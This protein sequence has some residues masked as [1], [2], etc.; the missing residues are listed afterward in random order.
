MRGI[1]TLSIFVALAGIVLPGC[2]S[3]DKYMKVQDEL[4]AAQ[5]E[6]QF[7]R[8]Q[9]SRAEAALAEGSVDSEQMKALQDQLA[10]AKQQ[11]D[12]YAK[13]YGELSG[14]SKALSDVGLEVFNAG[15]GMV[16]YRGLSDVFFASGSATLTSEG[17]HALD[18]LVGMIKS[19]SG[20]IRV[21][22][23]TDT[24]PVVKTKDQ[25]PA[26]NI[27]LGAKR[28]ISVR[29]YLIEKGIDESRISIESW[30]QYKPVAKG[31]SKEDKAHN[32]RVEILVP[33]AKG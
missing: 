5:D 26:G 25:Y 11:A 28:A 33:M 29:A 12:E 19:D 10:A 30:A 21:S 32:R 7:T 17:K 6:L 20:P 13:K 8:D 16:G 23:H 24:D 9:L 18:T 14:Q 2:V 22:G 3:A 27:E 1:R 4:Q 31:S 15:N